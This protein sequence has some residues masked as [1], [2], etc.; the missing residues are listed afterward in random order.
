[1]VDGAINSSPSIKF[2]EVKPPARVKAIIFGLHP[3]SAL[4]REG[5][6]AGFPSGHV[7][8]YAQAQ[9]GECWFAD[10]AG[11]I[12]NHALAASGVTSSR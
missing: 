2:V 5:K 4:L 9:D 3:R 6:R 8:P 10:Q 7:P 12:P 1:V 11:L